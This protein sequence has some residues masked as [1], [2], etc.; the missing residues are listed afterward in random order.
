MADSGGLGGGGC[1]DEWLQARNERNAK[2][3][4]D[5]LR[6]DVQRL[7]AQRERN[8][9]TFNALFRELGRVKTN[10]KDLQT[11]ERK[12]NSKAKKAE[13]QAAKRQQA[14]EKMPSDK[15]Q[16]MAANKKK[17]KEVVATKAV[18]AKKGMKA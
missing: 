1:V 15:W 11:N 17:A 12:R 18:K 9:E 3:I 13:A 4:I 16:K 2:L 8:R 7:M 14:K 5:G 10:V 6:V